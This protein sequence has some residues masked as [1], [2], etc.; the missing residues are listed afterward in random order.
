MATWNIDQ[1]HSTIGF[2]VKH[3]MVSTVRGHFNDFSGSITA[4]DDSFENASI[5]FTAQ[6][7]SINTN[8]E[9][10]DGHLKGADFFD[11]AAFPTI[12]FESSAFTKKG[13]QYVLDGVLTIKGVSK[14]VQLSVTTEGI[15]TGMDGKRV[16]GFELQGSIER[17]AFGLE[18]NA[19]LAGGGFVVSD[20]VTLDIHVEVVEA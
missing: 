19:P 3:L 5:H 18:W 14:P 20:T 4:S 7:G 6:T 10:R 13:D 17:S 15:G 8:N 16:A 11:A 9:G 12:S 1:A 2:K